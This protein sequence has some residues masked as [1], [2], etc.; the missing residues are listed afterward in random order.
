[1]TLYAEGRAKRQR[2]EYRQAVAVAHLTVA[3]GRVPRNKKLP[4]LE[5]LLPREQIPLTPKERR[6]Q[7]I[8]VMDAFI[9]PKKRRRF[10]ER[11]GK[12]EPQ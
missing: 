5:D 7:T 12:I 3:L 1:M 2:E 6:A 4:R 9:A 8:M 10:V 11:N